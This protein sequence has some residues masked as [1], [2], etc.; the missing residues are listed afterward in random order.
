MPATSFAAD[1]LPLFR[2]GDISDMKPIG[3]DL[4]SY[5]DVK[6]RAKDI[7]GRLSAKDMPCDQP[8]SAQDIEKFKQWVGTVA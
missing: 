3:V 7:Y 1:I 6:K 8:W 4:S 5:E 2:S